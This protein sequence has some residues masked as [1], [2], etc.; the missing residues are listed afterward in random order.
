MTLD[1]E[2]KSINEEYASVSSQPNQGI[3]APLLKKE[4]TTSAIFQGRV[5]RILNSISKSIGYSKAR[6]DSELDL[7]IS[8][9]N[10][11]LESRLNEKLASLESFVGVLDSKLSTYQNK[12]DTIDSVTKGLESIVGLLGNKTNTNPETKDISHNP[13]DF[14]YLLL[15][16]RF[17]GSEESIKTKLI[18]Y[19]ELIK[20][21][22][23]M[24][25]TKGRVLEV[26]SG[27]GEFLELLKESNIP[28]LGSEIDTGMYE[29]AKSK[30]LEMVLEDVNK[31]LST[32]TE[33]FYAITAFQV[34][35]H[36]PYPYL[37]E[38]LKNCFN[39]T[40][41]GG[42]ILLETINTSSLVPLMQNYFR[43]P[44]HTAPLHPD[45]LCFLIEQAGFK[46][47]EIHKTSNYPKEA[48]IQE[49][50]EVPE[51]PF[52]YQELSRQLNSRIDALNRLLF[53]SQD[54]AVEA[55][56]P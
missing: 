47:K 1:E 42:M 35:E 32:S 4:I 40:V 18:P 27:R 12:L 30:N 43:D 19:A 17:R 16:N 29:L 45:T 44:T 50:P 24:H 14:N 26:G 31:F 2:L 55:Y 28:A 48:L 13:P 49:I 51:L 34:V 37:L 20:S 36:M 56:K 39:R 25:S 9:S 46:L 52:R 38:F 53:D 54:Y 3:L 15:E 11:E 23:E 41:T 21:K 7:K 10:H 6:F 22:I 8:A 33:E 5:I